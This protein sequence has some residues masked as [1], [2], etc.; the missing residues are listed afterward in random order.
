VTKKE[1]EDRLIEVNKELDTYPAQVWFGDKRFLEFW[2]L[3]LEQQALEMSLEFA[4]DLDSVIHPNEFK[5]GK[6]DPFES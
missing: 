1:T 4:K 5:E 6:G 3:L 2:N